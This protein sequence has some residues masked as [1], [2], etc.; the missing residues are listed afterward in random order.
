[1]ELNV[2]TKFDIGDEVIVNEEFRGQV[3]GI[4][5]SVSTPPNANKNIF[6]VE[7]TYLVNVNEDVIEAA[8]NILIKYWE[9]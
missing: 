9:F 2:E 6:I 4:R 1:M 5:V 8:E 7:K 3:M